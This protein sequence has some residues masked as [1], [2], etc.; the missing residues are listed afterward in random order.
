MLSTSEFF[1]YA[2]ALKVK[3]LVPRIALKSPQKIGILSKAVY[4]KILV[5][6][7]E[8]FVF[9]PLLVPPLMC[10]IICFTPSISPV[11]L[12]TKQN[13]LLRFFLMFS[14]ALIPDCHCKILCS[15]AALS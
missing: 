9:P 4:I 7:L 14:I 15:E 1:G 3:F 12:K 6:K 13:L 11:I 5:D 8:C 10:F 2:V